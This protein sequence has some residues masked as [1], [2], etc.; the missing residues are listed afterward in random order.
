MMMQITQEP[1]GW[2]DAEVDQLLNTMTTIEQSQSAI[3]LATN[4]TTEFI[5]VITMAVFFMILIAGINLGY[6]ISP[7]FLPKPQDIG[8]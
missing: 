6:K 4:N 2:S 8:A 7:Y 3:E 1:K 5:D